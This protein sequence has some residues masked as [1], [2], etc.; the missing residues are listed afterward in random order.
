MRYDGLSLESADEED[1]ADEDMDR[2][3]G[4][5]A[6][7]PAVFFVGGMRNVSVGEVTAPGA[8][9]D[10]IKFGG[11]G[12]ASGGFVDDGLPASEVSRDWEKS[13]S[14]FRS[15]GPQNQSAIS[16]LVCFALHCQCSPSSIVLHPFDPG[17]WLCLCANGVFG[18]GDASGVPAL[19]SSSPSSSVSMFNAGAR[20][21]ESSIDIVPL[22]LA[23]ASSSSFRFLSSFSFR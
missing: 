17:L 4:E 2:A 9:D 1:D 18:E 7:A 11:M 3:R 12:M 22:P 20:S 6:M 15:D 5:C 13:G 10:L 8:E 23:T 19:E 16:A 21:P 14:S